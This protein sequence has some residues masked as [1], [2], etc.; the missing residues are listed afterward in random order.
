M[1]KMIPFFMLPVITR[2]MPNSYYMGLS[3]MSNTLLSFSQAFAVMGMYDAMFRMFFEKEEQIYKKEV[4]SSAVAFICLSS[5]LVFL[6][7]FTFKEQIAGSFFADSSLIPLVIV[8]AVGVLAGATNNIVAAPTRMQNKRRIFLATNVITPLISYGIAIYFL[9]K[10]NYIYALPLGSVIAAIATEVIFIFLNYKWFSLKFVRWNLIKSMLCI[11][12]PLLPNFL[13]YWVFNS[14]DRIMISQFLGMEHTGLYAV[15]AKFGHISQLIYSAF[16]GGWQYFA[17]STM[18]DED[19]VELTAKV[20][21]YLGCLA[22]SATILISFCSEFFF[23]FLFGKIYQPAAITVPYLFMAP[24]AQMLFQIA[25]NQFLVIKRTLPSSVILSVGAIGNIALN[26]VLIPRLGI[27][28]AAIATLAGF[29]LST[30]VCVFVLVR[31]G[32][33]QVSIRCKKV[34]A[35]FVLY[36]IVWRFSSGLNSWISI[37]SGGIVLLI[38]LNLYKIDIKR[39]VSADI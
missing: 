10:G 15:G 38:Y 22:F 18:R 16:A 34:V 21:E 24:L 39:L 7:L 13:I 6:F 27:E 30:L 9:S 33:F 17:F 20:F 25:A 23:C 11:G 2:L 28:G 35:F 12:I 14:C 37:L 36:L 32:L 19:Q 31:L 29:S 4:C 5:L 8:T 26:A 1:G 3:D